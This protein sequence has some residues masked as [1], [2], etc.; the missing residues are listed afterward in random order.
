MPYPSL[1]FHKYIGQEKMQNDRLVILVSIATPKYT[2]SQLQMQTPSPEAC[3]HFSNQAPLFPSHFQFLL[4]TQSSKKQKNT[5]PASFS[6]HERWCFPQAA[7]VPFSHRLRSLPASRPRPTPHDSDRS[8][9]S[10]ICGPSWRHVLL[11]GSLLRRQ[12]HRRRGIGT[13]GSR[14]GILRL[15]FGALCVVWFPLFP[16]NFI[17]KTFPFTV[18]RERT[19]IFFISWEN[20]FDL[21]LFCM[22]FYLPGKIYVVFL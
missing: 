17:G 8:F 12:Y 15:G 6:R 11:I 20:N 19:L 1:I 16:D 3:F 18:E 13:S 5:H 21:K 2:P 22:W 4:W 10:T 14:I 9:R 7:H